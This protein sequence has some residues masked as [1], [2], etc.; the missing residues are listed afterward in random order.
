M[1][2]VSQSK[3]ISHDLVLF[4]I[5]AAA[6]FLRLYGI[7]FGLPHLY[8]ADEPIIVNHALA[9]GTGDF[10]P[11]FFKIPPL[12]SYAAFAVYGVYFLISRA[13]GL[14]GNT[15]EFEALF[16]Q[17]P[18]SFYLLGRIIFGALLG[19]LTVY[20]LYR[21]VR[22]RFGQ[23][24]ALLSSFLLAVNFLHV[25][26]SH[27]IY[28]DIPLVLLLVVGFI[29]IQDIVTG[30]Q[31]SRKHLYFG[32]L[33][34]TAIA[35]KYN[36]VL[37]LVPYML[38][39]VMSRLRPDEF[40]KKVLICGIAA[41]AAFIAA[42]PYAVLDYENFLS[43]LSVQSKSHG[44]VGWLH[45]LDYSLKGAGGLLFLLFSLGGLGLIQDKDVKCTQFKGLAAVF[46]MIYYAAVSIGGQHYDR[47]VLPMIPFL[48]FF[49]A[50]CIWTLASYTGKQF[51]RVL[52]L[53]VIAASAYSL[54]ASLVWG[55]LMSQPDT[56]TE[57]KTWIESNVPS[58]SRIALDWNFFSPR[59]HFSDGQLKGKRAQLISGE[60]VHSGAKIRRI[61]SLLKGIEKGK[62]SYE[63]HFLSEDPDNGKHFLMSTPTIPYQSTALEQH[64]IQYVVTVR[65]QETV[66][67]Q[68]FY[69]WL[70][71]HADPVAAFSPYKNPALHAWP[72]DRISL[73][74]GPFLREELINRARNGQP[75]KIYR[76][77]NDHE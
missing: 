6:L 28:A 45:H 57:A 20:A 18:G 64:K 60:A 58:G 39:L 56:R 66:A 55:Q 25:R 73:T 21:L 24:Q 65:L 5:L 22:T 53:L 15:S 29:L 47:Y 43:E 34:G 61:D 1:S 70:E 63:L 76:L 11:H 26:D 13:A 52:T 3:I 40:S 59:V 68:E 12:V 31:P 7:H 75:I 62:S 67:W 72:I 44:G 23:G 71:H 69:D 17:D 2:T 36:G 33:L 54:S 19:T 51:K 10:N 35:V 42:T 27:Y 9:Y 48:C 8:H 16:Y 49:A 32:L 4:L 41:F 50:H 46:V 74:G 14:V 77:R 38:S 30:A 37:L